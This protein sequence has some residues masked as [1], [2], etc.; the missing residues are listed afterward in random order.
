ERLAPSPEPR[1]F[2][3]LAEPLDAVDEAIA[4]QEGRIA[5][6]D[7]RIGGAVEIGAAPLLLERPLEPLEGLRQ[8][9]RRLA[10]LRFA[11]GIGA[12]GDRR[13]EARQVVGPGAVGRARDRIGRM[14]ARR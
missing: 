7:Q 11:L 4:L 12:S 8:L 2:L 14:K 3:D 9:R 10:E 6:I 1:E 13:S 5:G